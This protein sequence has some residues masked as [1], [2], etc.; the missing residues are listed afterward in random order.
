[1][2][3]VSNAS[4]LI[5]LGRIGLLGLLPQLYGEL[6][7]PEAVWLEVVVQ[8]RGQPGAHEVEIADWVRVTSVTNLALVRALRQEL[9]AG[10]AEAIALTLEARADMSL[11]DEHLGRETALHM[12]VQCV[13][14]V[15]VLVEAKHRGLIE[16]VRPLLDTLRDIAGL[17]VSER[18]Y[19]RVLLDEG[20]SPH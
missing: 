18:L 14:L 8:G 9:D 12:G 2:S 20:E 17:W 16:Q 19:Q 4:P 10:E 15:G 13:G 3:V 5:N 1:M 11:M 6:L 7:V